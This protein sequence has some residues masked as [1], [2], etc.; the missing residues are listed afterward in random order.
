MQYVQFGN[1]DLKVS[2]IGLDTRAI[3]G[4]AYAGGVCLGRIPVDDSLSVKALYRAYDC[5][6]NFFDT[7]DFY[8]SGHA[9]ELIGKTFGNRPDVVIALKAGQRRDENNML[10]TDCSAAYL[11][12]CCEQSLRRLRREAIDFYQLHGAEVSFLKSGEAEALLQALRQEG[13]IRWYGISLTAFRP[14]PEAEFCMENRFGHGFQAVFNI[15]NQLIAPYLSLMQQN[16]FGVIA[17]MPLQGGLLTGKYGANTV[18]PPGD[19]RSLCLTPPVLQEAQ[20]LLPFL[21]QLAR[22]YEMSLAELAMSFVL[23]HSAVSTVISAACTPE[24]AARNARIPPA[25]SESDRNRLMQFWQQDCSQ[26]FALI[27]KQG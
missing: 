21:Q 14:E 12:R 15:F 24:Q 10:R 27:K 3:G 25:I 11:R 19:Y 22:D 17:R 13:K 7:A 9:E 23:S 26:L 8:G 16:G 1:T 5:G 4:E 20:K 6:I 18:F 2:R